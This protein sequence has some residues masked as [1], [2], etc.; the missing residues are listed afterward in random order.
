[1]RARVS[2]GGV[3]Y[4][5]GSPDQVYLRGLPTAGPNGYNAFLTGIEIEVDVTDLDNAGGSVTS[6]ELHNLATI[7]M[8]DGQEPWGPSAIPGERLAQA[9]YFATGESIPYSAVSTGDSDST[10]GSN[11]TRFFRHVYSFEAFGPKDDPF[12]FCPPCNALK[13]GSVKFSFS[14][15]PTNATSI[16]ATYTVYAHIIYRRAQQAVPRLKTV[17]QAFVG[18]GMELTVSGILVQF[19]ARSSSDIVKGDFTALRLY[20][21]GFPLITGMNPVAAR[22]RKFNQSAKVTSA[23]VQNTFA[24]PIGGNFPRA[25][26]VYPTEERPALGDLP[27]ADTYKVEFEGALTVA[28]W[29]ALVTYAPPISD[30]QATR[31]LAGCGCESLAGKELVPLGRGGSVLTSKRL[32]RLTPMI[33]VSK[34]SPLARIKKAILG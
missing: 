17:Q 8:D 29:T 12:H 31:Q 6:Q 1:M 11:R 13:G 18:T 33:A 34:G 9:D 10:A 24:D 14:A 25:A 16:T 7:T 22:P 30:E 28:N 20:A 3:S 27:V 26:L 19:V 2:L 4:A 21:D 32:A 15:L 5:A 23:E